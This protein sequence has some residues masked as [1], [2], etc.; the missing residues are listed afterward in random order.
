MCH[1]GEIYIEMV[2]VTDNLNDNAD[3]PVVSKLVSTISMQS[4]TAGKHD[5]GVQIS[6]DAR[7][8]A[9]CMDACLCASGTCLQCCQHLGHLNIHNMY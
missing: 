3:I 7:D 4:A 2:S 1:C 9:A 6:Y 8:G 5:G